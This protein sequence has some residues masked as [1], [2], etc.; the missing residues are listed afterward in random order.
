MKK[1]VVPISGG[2]DST[3]LL[4]K[5]SKEF[6]KVYCLS[7]DYGQ[8]HGRELEYAKIQVEYAKRNGKAHIEHQVLDVGFLKELVPTSS[9]T[10]SD[11]DTPDV[12]EMKGEAQPQSYV[13]NRNMIFLSIAVA[14]AEAVGAEVWHGAA[15][16]DSLAGYWDGSVE[17]LNS[18]ND[19]LQLNREN[20]VK[21]KATLIDMSKKEIV[22][23]GVELGVRFSETYTCYTGDKL[24]SIYSASSSLRLKGFIDAGYADPILYKEQK[25]LTD[26]YRELG[27]KFIPHDTYLINLG[28]F[29]S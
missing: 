18:Y 15:Q 2:M 21:V 25:L 5:A 16:A 17:F 23:L 22:E 20:P 29:V 24:P 7:Y 10:N 19:L 3:V 8:R 11:I 28:D 1:V 4:H 13:P 9:L 26:K 27:S 6:D 14:K 12:R